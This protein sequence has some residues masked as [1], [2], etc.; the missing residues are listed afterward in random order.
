MTRTADDRS[1]LAPYEKVLFRSYRE[2][3]DFEA[4]GTVAGLFLVRDLTSEAGWDS[5]NSRKGFVAEG[6]FA[7]TRS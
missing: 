7:P 3:R 2:V 6:L 1:P 5:I 4:R